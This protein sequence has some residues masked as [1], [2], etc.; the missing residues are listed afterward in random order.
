MQGQL[1]Q[2]MQQLCDGQPR[3]SPGAGARVS[4]LQLSTR[5]MCAGQYMDTRS[6]NADISDWSSRA[7]ACACAC[8]EE[9]CGPAAAALLAL[10]C[11]VMLQMYCLYSEATCAA[12]DGRHYSVSCWVDETV[13]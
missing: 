4:R 13:W 10:R 2:C 3:G 12:A 11:R 6:T 7:A 5:L 9:P 8:C 1:R